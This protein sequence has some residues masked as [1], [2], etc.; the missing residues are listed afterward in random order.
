MYSVLMIS[1]GAI[2]G[3]LCRWQLGI[4]LNPILNQFT[5]GTLF[6][7]WIGCFLIGLSMGL[8]LG[9]NQRL[10]LITGFLGSFTTFSSFS[11][12]LSE[13]LLEGK[14]LQFSATLSLHLA[15]GILLTI[16]G[17]VFIRLLTSGHF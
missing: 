5:L 3:G 10:L 8:N 17:I 12:E 13:K 16:A 9:D 6:A 7:N 11:L 2:L 15:G 4:W 1:M 14:L